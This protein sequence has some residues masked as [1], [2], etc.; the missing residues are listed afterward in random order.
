MQFQWAGLKNKE[1]DLTN[2]HISLSVLQR[3]IPSNV[4]VSNFILTFSHLSLRLSQFS[5]LRSW[6]FHLPNGKAKSLWWLSYKQ[7][8]TVRI[9]DTV[10]YQCKLV[11]SG[12]L[13]SVT[14]VKWGGTNLLYTASQDRTVKVWKAD[15]VSNCCGYHMLIKFVLIVL[16]F[17]VNAACYILII[18]LMKFYC[19]CRL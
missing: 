15:D 7:D 16:S 2:L 10:L 3:K 9:W 5:W 18:I 11:L 8:G 6:S 1:G 13:Q 4:L 19:I 12:H 17:T 14:C